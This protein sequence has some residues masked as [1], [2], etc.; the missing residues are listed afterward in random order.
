M[1]WRY[2]YRDNDGVVTEL[3]PNRVQVSYDPNHPGTDGFVMNA[4][5]GSVGTSAITVNDPSGNFE[6]NGLR[7]FIVKETACAGDAYDGIVYDGYTWVRTYSR[8]VERVGAGRTIEMQLSDINTLFERR[9]MVGA[10]NNRPAETDVERITWLLSTSEASFIG[11]QTYFSTSLPT[12]MDAADYRGQSFRNIFDDCSQ[13]SGKNWF[14]WR[15][16]AGRSIW[17]AP[18]GTSTFASAIKISNDPADL[19]PLGTFGPV[20]FEPAMD[21]HLVR[22]PSRVYSGTWENYASS[23]VY[24]QREATAV[25]FARRDSV[26]YAPN[27]KTKTKAILRANRVLND[28]ATEEDVITTAIIVPIAQTNDVVAGQ[29]IQV[30]FTHFAVE[31]YGSYVWVRVLNRT[32][33]QVNDDY[34]ELRLT[35]SPDEPVDQAAISGN[36]FGILARCA[37]YDFYDSAWFDW[38]GDY[39]DTGGGVQPTVGLITALF[40]NAGPLAPTWVYY[41]WLIGGT[42]TIDVT[43]YT[44][45]IGITPTSVSW[46]ILKNGIAVATT[47]QVNSGNGN[48]GTVSITGLA[49]V[50]G[51]IITSAVHCTPSG[52]P[53]F[54]APRGTGDNSEAL[55]I[56]GGTLV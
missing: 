38:V 14:L 41:G 52:T 50:P 33:K 39:P 43:F 23:H 10:D 31:G 36:V 15:A 44:S 56:T 6:V 9:I 3:T 55:T 45:T 4:E 40:D 30:K 22:D 54:R 21:T 42:G 29:R 2:Y 48:D 17:Y 11:D 49:V 20:V 32:V 8:D 27:V 25:A 18:R 26:T 7:V 35:L 13:Q 12:N 5:E 47:T 19:A 37:T 16:A 28:I 53:F 46:L 51:D 34:T 24:V 1:A